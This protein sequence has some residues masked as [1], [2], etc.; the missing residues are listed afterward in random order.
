MFQLLYPQ[1]QTFW[2]LLNRR[3]GQTQ[4]QSRHLGEEKNLSSAGNKT[5][6][7]PDNNLVHNNPYYFWNIH[8][9]LP[10]LHST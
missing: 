3:L 10:P 7:H 1:R 6:D 4:I 2:Y 5:L 8:Q 9:I